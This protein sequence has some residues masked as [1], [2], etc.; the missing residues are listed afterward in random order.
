MTDRLDEAKRLHA[1]AT[2][3]P[4]VWTATETTT[5]EAAV[6]WFRAKISFGDDGPIH[7]VG[8]PTHPLT[9]LGDDPMRPDHM[10]EPAT[11]GNGPTS[12]KNAQCIAAMHDLAPDL[13]ALAEAAER[14]IENSYRDEYDDAVVDEKD[15]DTL[16]A[17]VDR[18][19]G[20]K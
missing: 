7:G 8:C 6:E 14:C 12:A 13:F 15:F 16:R 5:K 19:R 2:P 3:G 9:V 17:A 11:T 10:V 4:W 18:V 1:A 20:R